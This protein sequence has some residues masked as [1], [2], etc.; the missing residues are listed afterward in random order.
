M[1]CLFNFSLLEKDR[2]YDFDCIIHENTQYFVLFAVFNGNK[3][4]LCQSSFSICV[5]GFHFP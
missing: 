3:Q 1:K 4:I 5:K 2:V